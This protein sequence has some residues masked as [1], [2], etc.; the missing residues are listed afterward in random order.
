MDDSAQGKLEES[1][2][3]KSLRNTLSSRFLGEVRC[4]AQVTGGLKCRPYDRDILQ[5]DR[6]PKMC[7][8]CPFSP[9][10]CPNAEQPLELK[11]GDVKG[12]M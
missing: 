1:A 5:A 9:G 7:R 10:F 11:T 6:S 12:Q 2:G 3:E 4:L 8:T